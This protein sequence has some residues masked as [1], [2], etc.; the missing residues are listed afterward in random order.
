MVI[1]TNAIIICLKWRFS[2]YELLVVGILDAIRNCK[3]YQSLGLEKTTYKNNNVQ[4]YLNKFEYGEKVF[5]KLISKSETFIYFS[6]ITCKVKHFKRVVL[7][8]ILMIRAYSSWKS[9]ISIS[10]Y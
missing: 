9:K 5:L 2:M 4:V 10:K 8:L 7:F 6:Y 3:I 1:N